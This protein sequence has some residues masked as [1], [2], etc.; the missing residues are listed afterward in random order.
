MSENKLLAE[1]SKKL[2]N[3]ANALKGEMNKFYETNK[4]E[5]ITNL[6]TAMRAEFKPKY[7]AFHDNYF[8]NPPIGLQSGS[9]AVDAMEISAKIYNEL[10][11]YPLSLYQAHL[12]KNP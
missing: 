3:E 4:T 6:I 11:N 7:L 9:V 1:F 10:V 8:M 5:T 2:E 12:Q